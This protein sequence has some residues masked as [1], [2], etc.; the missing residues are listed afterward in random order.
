[1][2]ISTYDE[3]DTAVSKWSH[4]RSDILELIPDFITL[5]EHEI[6]S[7]GD[8]QLNIKTIEKTSTATLNGTL[9][10]QTRFLAL[11]D[12]F[13]S[14]RDF[15]LIDGN[16]RIKQI[17]KTPIQLSVNTSTGRPTHYTI[18]N[19]IEF[20]I[21]ADKDYII[22]LK[23]LATPTPINSSNQTNEV[24]TNDPNIYL[25]GALAQVY[26]FSEEQ[27][28]MAKW[29]AKFIDAIRGANNRANRGRYSVSPRMRVKGVTP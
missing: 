11:P 22:E 19:Q 26:M 3:L 5:A 21:I 24:L 27:E 28:E 20:N 15:T 29:Y 23:Y 7:N 2:A 10:S 16:Q 12:G 25:Y 14:D 1:M 4:N 13:L 8:E 6:Y 18:T 17:Y 9:P